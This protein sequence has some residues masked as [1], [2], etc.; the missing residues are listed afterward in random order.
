MS[1]QQFENAICI[2]MMGMGRRGAR[3]HQLKGRRRRNGEVDAQGEDFRS[4]NKLTPEI[5]ADEID[6]INHLTR[7]LF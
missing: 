2:A 3:H 1:A 4:G 7:Y 5:V 6:A